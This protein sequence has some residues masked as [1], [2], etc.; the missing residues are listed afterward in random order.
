MPYNNVPEEKIP[1]MDRCVEKVQGQ[2]HDKESAIAICYT[3]VVEGKALEDAIK[4]Y[5]LDRAVEELKIGARNSSTDLKRIQEAHELLADLGANCRVKSD[6]TELP[7]MSLEVDNDELVYQ[8]DAVKALG[9]GKLGGYLVRF[10]SDTDPDL[11]GEFFTKDTNYGDYDKSDGYYEHGLDAFIGKQNIGVGKVSITTDDF[12]KWAEIQLDKRVKYEKFLYEMGKAGKLGWSSGTLPNLVEYEKRGKATWIKKWPIGLD[13]SL[14]PTPAEPRNGVMPLKSIVVKPLMEVKP[15]DELVTEVATQEGKEPE[16]IIETTKPI[17]GVNTMEITEEK[18]QEVIDNAVASGVEKAMKALPAKPADVS[19]VKDEADQPWKSK[20][21]F[22]QAVKMAAIH[23]MSEDVRLRPLKATG[24]SEGVPADGGYLVAPQISTG[25]L[26][27]VYK[28]GEILGRVAV[29]EIGPNSNGMIYNAIDE[30]SRADG[31]R[32]G[33]LRGYW[34]N[35]GGSKTATKPKF[36]QVELKL[37]KL[38]VLCYATDE[39]LADATALDSWL[40]RT[41]PN[42]IRFDVENAIYNGDG[43]GK[44]LGIMNSACRVA[45]TRVTLLGVDSTD[46]ATMWSR[47]YVGVSDYVWFINPAVFPQLINLVVGNFP[48]LAWG[49][50]QGQPFPTIYGKPVIE[51]EYAPTLGTTGDIMLASLSQYQTIRKGGVEAA[52]SIHVAFTTDEQVFR[53]VYRTDG[54]PTWYSALTPYAGN[55]SSP[56]VVLATATV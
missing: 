26:E 4:A 43:V 22:F 55:T 54:S 10:S 40:T 36:R 14:T 30:T 52:S 51:I 8:G 37:K 27:N 24:M 13:A 32:F 17:K 48:L 12:G 42:E 44:P 29:D 34:L 6:I 56:F 53:F 35:E 5:Q 23:P 46:I 1:E 19:V 3:S 28:T 16:A 20:G 2:G 50:I 7:L 11:T 25:I 39:L 21:E 38:A 33:G 41:V 9:D 18:L 49:G 45:P 15:T 47:R 31:S